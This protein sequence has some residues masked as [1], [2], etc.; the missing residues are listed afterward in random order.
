VNEGARRAG[1][2]TSKVQLH[3]YIRICVDEDEAVAR[4]A[5]T[6]AILGY[7]L[8][9][10]GASKEHGYRGHFARMGF[11]EA[12][13]D[14]ETRR[15]RGAAESEIIEAFSREL[16]KLVGYYGPA[17]AAAAAFRRLAEGLDIAVVR[18]VPARPGFDA[19][20]AV[21]RACRPEL[22]PAGA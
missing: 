14:L 9:R 1:R 16:L 17:D 15:E 19:V 22:V 13:T 3:E 12:L 7:A 8:A 11:D 2:D 4:R 6:K 20:A 5:Y 10:P 21:M 18:V